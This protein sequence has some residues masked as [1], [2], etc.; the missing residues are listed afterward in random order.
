MCGREIQ[1][2]ADQR[3]I[4]KMEVIACSALQPLTEADLD[5]DAMQAVSKLIHAQAE[6]GA[7]ED[8]IPARQVLRYDLC[9]TCRQKFINDPLGIEAPH[10]DF[11][12]N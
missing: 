5:Q 2:T 11:S 7:S 4:V 12:T 1:P 3:Y 9:S 8:D 6:S 10:F